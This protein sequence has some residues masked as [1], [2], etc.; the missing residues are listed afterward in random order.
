[1]HETETLEGRDFPGLETGNLCGFVNRRQLWVVG[2]IHQREALRTS[3]LADDLTDELVHSPG[4]YAVEREEACPNL[5]LRRKKHEIK[6]A[7]Y[8]GPGPQEAPLTRHRRAHKAVCVASHS[9]KWSPQKEITDGMVLQSWQP[10][11]SLGYYLH[12]KHTKSS[13]KACGSLQPW[14]LFC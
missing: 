10:L 11:K 3:E 7:E 9:A 6:D 1:M 14:G 13:R 2:H 8:L 4:T 12:K 5:P